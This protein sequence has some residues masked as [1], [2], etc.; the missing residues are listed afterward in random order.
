MQAAG[1][2]RHDAVKPSLGS[3]LA[4]SFPVKKSGI[5]LLLLCGVIAL[6]D[7]GCAFL[8]LLL[9]HARLPAPALHG[10]DLGVQAAVHGWESPALTVLMHGLTFIGSIE[11]FIPTLLVAVALLLWRGEREGGRRL[12]RKRQVAGVFA[13]GVGG[14]LLLNDSFKVYFHRARPAVPWAIGDEQTFSFPSGHSLFSILL[15][16]LIAYTLVSRRSRPLHRAATM[17]GAA[18]L[19]AGIG[20]SRIYLGM[21]WPTDV[22]AGYITGGM[23][24]AGVILI[25]RRWRTHWQRVR[26]TKGGE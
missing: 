16:G 13:L 6:A 1:F 12:I 11:V 5:R 26:R 21:H 23:W 20:L 2:R 8:L 14:A 19:V 22:L 7:A 25:D 9:L 18:S 3:L 4:S 15:Y 17:V 10:F 24:L